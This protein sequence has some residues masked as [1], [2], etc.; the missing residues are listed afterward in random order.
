MKFLVE[1][2][3]RS[4]SHLPSKGVLP[5]FPKK[6]FNAFFGDS[7]NTGKVFLQTRRTELENYYKLLLGLPDFRAKLLQHGRAFLL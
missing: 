2:F 3:I 1:S 4:I 5:A 6:N 7:S